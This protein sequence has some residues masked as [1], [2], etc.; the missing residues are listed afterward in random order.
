MDLKEAAMPGTT[1]L[2]TET[3]I[4]TYKIASGDMRYIEINQRNIFLRQDPNLG[5][6]VRGE[7]PGCGVG[8]YADLSEMFLEYAMTCEGCKSPQEAEESV[9][10]FGTSL[11][12]ILVQR[13][14][15]KLT[16]QEAVE[17]LS[18]A[19]EFT[20]KSMTVPF[21]IER[22]EDQLHFALE[23]CPLCDSGGRLGLNRELELA[24]HG[25]I[26]L[27]QSM[28]YALAPHWSLRTPSM[29]D[30]QQD[31]IDILLVKN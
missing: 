10:G 7:L 31:L 19:F 18:I 28:I 13:L 16:D 11:G 20:L 26:A 3:P 27:C 1:E 24:R 12:E 30:I 14:G 8:C 5:L 22:S 21:S 17:R 4:Y 29:Q 25:F 9:A 15:P 23:Y 2:I 6:I